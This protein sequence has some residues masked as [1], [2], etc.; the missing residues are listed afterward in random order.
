[1]EQKV[2]LRGDTGPYGEVFTR[3][4]S[5]RCQAEEQRR[6]PQFRSEPEWQTRTRVGREIDRNSV[7][8]WDVGNRVVDER[9]KTDSVWAAVW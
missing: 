7:E 1:M 2:I 9:I 6:V 3:A 8:A 4:I 5:Q